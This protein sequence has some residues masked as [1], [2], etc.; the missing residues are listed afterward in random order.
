MAGVDTPVKTRKRAAVL[1]A[2]GVGLIQLL[3]VH[4]TFSYPFSGMALMNFMVARVEPGSPA[5]VA[6]L[7]DGDVITA[8]DGVPTS[9]PYRCRQIIESGEV[10]EALLLDVTR[11]DRPFRVEL[12][13]ERLPRGEA[14]LHVG[15]SAVSIVFLLLAIGVYLRRTDRLGLLFFLL[16]SSLAVLLTKPLPIES[17]YLYGAYQGMRGLAERFVPPFFLHFFLL[18]PEGEKTPRR[19]V[20]AAVYTPA[21]ALSLGFLYV[22]VAGSF[23]GVDVGRG[24]SLLL[25]VASSVYFGLCFLAGAALFVVAYYRRRSAETR[26]RLRVALWGTVAG[27]L[28]IALVTV[29]LN[30]LPTIRIPGE[31]FF[32]FSIVLIPASFAYAIL[33]HR[34][35]DVQ[36]LL[37]RS[38]VYSALTALLL[39]VFFLMVTLFGEAVENLTGRSGLVVS[40]LSIFAIAVMA[41]PLRNKLQ[42][43]ADQIFFRKRRDSFR[44]LKELGDALSAAMDL[45]ALVMI[46]VSK[47]SSSLGLERVAVYVKHRAEGGE[48]LELKGGD[49]ETLPR[50]LQL[51]SPA[52]AALERAAGPVSLADLAKAERDVVSMRSSDGALRARGGADS[53]SSEVG[54]DTA[55]V[56]SHSAVLVAESP[57]AMATSTETGTGPEEVN[58]LIESGLKS[59][60]PFLAWGKLRGA[61]MLDVEPVALPP[62]QRELLAALADRAGTAVDNA[63]LYREALERHRLEKELSVARR[64]QEDLLPGEDPVFP[65]A[66]VSG[67]M[68]PSHEVGGDYYDYVSLKG[69]RLG[70]AIGDVTGKGIPAALLMAAVQA[71]LRAEAEREPSPAELVSRINKRVHTLQQPERFATFFY[72]CLDAGA[73]TLT[74]CNAGHHPP[75]LLRSAG[76][77][78]RLTEGGLL[79]GFQGDAPYVEGTIELNEGDTVVLYTDGIIE[80][81]DGRESFFGEEG[82]ME[83]I[84]A[85]RDLGAGQLKKRIIESVK[86]FSPSGSNDDDL[87]VVVIKVF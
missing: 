51:G 68:I 76:D 19:S 59:A 85:N 84:E 71:T 45:D 8:I 72:C 65:T 82:L 50:R 56:A 86:E 29:A 33:R 2:A 61:V 69:K 28:P 39:A 17:P 20:L 13:L 64:I 30:L 24:A 40:V 4:G 38:I 22:L 36:L 63:L 46:L 15:R 26:R 10:G 66:D 77:I 27:V 43:A 1:L 54:A 73:R 18:F 57:A 75:L 44:A 62:H 14:M 32:F 47:M 3:G 34:V 42:D 11:E 23:L 31:R 25:S 78:E 7:T 79:M 37:R 81:S 48:A 70:I 60:V 67:S 52:T 53:H 58:R 35:L 49:P 41:N 9:R 83:V 87:T 80:Q 55:A 6:G 16:C 74:Y 12:T 5:D 21:I